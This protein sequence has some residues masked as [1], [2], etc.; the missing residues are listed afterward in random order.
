MNKITDNLIMLYLTVKTYLA[1]SKM[2]LLNYITTLRSLKFVDK[3]NKQIKNGLFL[4]FIIKN[5]NHLIKMT[6]GL[7]SM[8]ILLRNS[9]DVKADKIQL[10][11]TVNE[12]MNTFIF[13]S[14]TRGIP[15]VTLNDVDE[16]LSKHSSCDNVIGSVIYLKLELQNG[17]DII[18]LKDF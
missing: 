9:V 10:V 2:T 4:F 12:T 15:N 11:H 7:S 13:D 16:Y 18:N 5:I 3:N 17:N 1:S 6:N 14:H 8:L